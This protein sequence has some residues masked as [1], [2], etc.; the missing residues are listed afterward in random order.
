MKRNKSTKKEDI[1]IRIRTCKK[2]KEAE[3]FGDLRNTR[4]KK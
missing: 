2:K 1:R 4:K 3:E